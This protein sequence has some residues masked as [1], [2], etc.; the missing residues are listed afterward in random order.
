MN[1][2]MLLG[3]QIHPQHNPPTMQIACVALQH[4][5]NNLANTQHPLPPISCLRPRARH[6]NRLIPCCMQVLPQPRVAYLF[7]LALVSL[8]LGL[9]LSIIVA[10]DFTAVWHS[11][12]SDQTLALIAYGFYCFIWRYWPVWDDKQR[13]ARW[14]W[15]CGCLV[16]RVNGLIFSMR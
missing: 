11:W 5:H 16:C 9:A 12:F 4:G 6:V 15:V 10:A 13:W 8:L 14:L 2:L 1:S 3:R 7:D